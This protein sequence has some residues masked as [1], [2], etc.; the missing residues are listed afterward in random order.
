MKNYF[1]HEA[2][3]EAYDLTWEMSTWDIPLTW[4]RL[5]KCIDL[6]FSTISVFQYFVS[7]YRKY[8]YEYHEINIFKH[9]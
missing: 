9:R 5:L 3:A 1:W 2:S 4:V 7:N 8:F 6:Y